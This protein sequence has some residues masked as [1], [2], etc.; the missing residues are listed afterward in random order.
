M[1][2]T[3]NSTT[4]MSRSSPA[5]AAMPAKAGSD[6]PAKNDNTFATMSPPNPLGGSLTLVVRPDPDALPVN[7]KNSTIIC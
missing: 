2:D 7:T 5:A 1:D 3:T 6:R 4:I